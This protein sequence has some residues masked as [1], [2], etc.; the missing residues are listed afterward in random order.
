[1]PTKKVNVGIV[2][3]GI[4]KPNARAI[5]RHAQGHAAAL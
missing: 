5:S 2:G 1:M 4:G 3:M